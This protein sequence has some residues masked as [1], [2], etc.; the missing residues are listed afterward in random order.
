MPTES[1]L[2][3]EGPW[4][5]PFVATESEAFDRVAKLQHAQGTRVVC[6]TIRGRKARTTASLFDEFAAALQFPCYFGENWDAFDEC[7]TDLEW[8][9]AEGYVLL[10][11]NS[12]H[13]LEADPL[14]HL[15][16]FF[17]LLEKAGREWS[18]PVGEL[19][20]RSARG[21]HVLLQCTQDEEPLMRVKFHAAKVAF[22][23][24]S[25]S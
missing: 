8:L 5:H 13:L 4:L 17:H 3:P 18:K 22:R 12:I 11:T 23:A 19:S 21:F 10:I 14:D 25:L 2:R 20:P 24:V 15:V 1:I 7:L 9:S 6:R 16:R